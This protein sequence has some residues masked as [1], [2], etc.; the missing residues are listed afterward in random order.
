MIRAI[1]TS[2]LYTLII[3]FGYLL[4][5]D[6]ACETNIIIAQEFLYSTHRYGFACSP[7]SDGGL[8]DFF[9]KLEKIVFQAKEIEE[10]L[11]PILRINQI[12]FDDKIELIIENIGWQDAENIVITFEDDNIDEYI[13]KDKQTIEIPLI[14]YGNSTN[15]LLWECID[16]KKDGHFNIKSKITG[17]NGEIEARYTNS[18]N[19]IE[20]DYESGKFNGKPG[21]GGQSGL[22]YGIEI[23]TETVEYKEEQTISECI[24]PH[25]RLELPI[26]FSAKKTCNFD[27]R[28]GFEVLTHNN[29]KKMIWSDYVDFRLEI[30]PENNIFINGNS[31]EENEIIENIQ[32]YGGLASYP[33]ISK[34]SIEYLNAPF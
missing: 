22:I 1:P 30:I 27:F 16:L 33:Y 14:K 2:M 4:C 26:C 6:M 18:Q 32:F 3:H 29:K 23:N 19:G 13:S 24:N 31:C 7:I 21:S 15:V 11:R 12:T 5:F 25:D 8:K 20:F 9:I 34:E 28:I 10:D 17:K